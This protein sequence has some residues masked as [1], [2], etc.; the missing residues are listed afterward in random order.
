MQGLKWKKLKIQELKV[1]L[2]LRKTIVCLMG[3]FFSLNN[4]SLSLS[5]SQPSSPLLLTESVKPLNPKLETLKSQPLQSLFSLYIFALSLLYSHLKTEASR[6]G[7]L[8]FVQVRLK[9]IDFFGFGFYQDGSVND[10]FVVVCDGFVCLFVCL[11]VFI[12]FILF[13][14]K[15]ICNGL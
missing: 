7:I 10:W 14:L 6:G 3:D 13:F 12:L 2:H 11:F 5:L 15:K 4:F 1:H 9:T 8:A